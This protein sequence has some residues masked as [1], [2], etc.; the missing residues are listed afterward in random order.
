MTLVLKLDLVIIMMYYYA[1]N[2]VCIIQKLQRK[3]THTQTDRLA[4]TDTAKTLPL[5]HTREVIS[6][7]TIS[8]SNGSKFAVSSHKHKAL[9]I[10][11]TAIAETT[12][13]TYP[14]I[15]SITHVAYVKFPD[16]L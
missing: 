3:Q 8:N 15:A 1:K 5:P 4:H 16:T 10:Q 9:H 11:R 12:Q 14:T 2:K 7:C 13:D 6:T